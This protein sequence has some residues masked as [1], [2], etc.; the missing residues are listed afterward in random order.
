MIHIVSIA[1]DLEDLFPA[2]LGQK[3]N[4]FSPNKTHFGSKSQ[5]APPKTI[6]S[7]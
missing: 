7:V 1:V 5:F 4:S 6:L 3:Y 2:T